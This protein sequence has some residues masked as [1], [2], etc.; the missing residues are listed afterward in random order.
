[1]VK[2]QFPGLITPSPVAAANSTAHH[3]RSSAQYLS[4]STLNPFSVKRAIEQNT[5]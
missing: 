2:A 3:N 1:V 5:S 4:K